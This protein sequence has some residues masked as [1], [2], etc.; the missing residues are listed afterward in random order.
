MARR[1]SRVLA[2]TLLLTACAPT[3]RL[4]PKED[5]LILLPENSQAKVTGHFKAEE[6]RT[7]WLHQALSPEQPS[8]VDLLA[9]TAGNRPIRNVTIASSPD[10]FRYSLKVAGG[11]GAWI[12]LAVASPATQPLGPVA[13]FVALFGIPDVIQV[14]VEGDFVGEGAAVDGGH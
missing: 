8:P 7:Y 9:R 11:L 5:S 3:M 1:L 10:W 2:L 14:Q 12:L 13:Y 4:S 6:R